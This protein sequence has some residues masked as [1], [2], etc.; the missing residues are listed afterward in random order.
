MLFCHPDVRMLLS[1]GRCCKHGGNKGEVVENTWRP[2]RRISERKQMQ[3][4]RKFNSTFFSLIIFHSIF[5]RQ[6]LL[7]I[8]CRIACNITDLF[9]RQSK[10]AL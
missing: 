2:Y 8:T 5:Q 4:S 3:K 6:F 9:L 1:R 7:A 10:T